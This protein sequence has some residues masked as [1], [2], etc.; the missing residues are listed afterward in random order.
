MVVQQVLTLCC[1][2]QVANLGLTF[3]THSL[4]YKN[5]GPFKTVYIRMVVQDQYN[6]KGMKIK[7]N[8]VNF[9]S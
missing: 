7:Q 5:K 6:M 3:I 2:L 8:S 4:A 1:S 9:Q